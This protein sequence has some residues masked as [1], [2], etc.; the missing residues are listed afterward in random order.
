MKSGS[1]GETA[2]TRLYDAHFEE[3][4]RYL[5]LRIGNVTEAEDL[6]SQTFY[7][8]LRGFS[9]LR[10][11][12]TSAS[13]WLYRIATNE[14]NSH[15]RRRRSRSRW[16]A[17]TSPAEEVVVRERDTA[18]ERLRREEIFMQLSG[19]LRR[20][21]P[22]EQA[23]V[24]LRYFER[25]PYAEIARI[26]RKREGTLAMRTHRALGKMRAELEKRGVDHE[27]IRESF[28]RREAAG[29]AGRRVQA[30]ATP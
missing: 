3:I 11:I 9:R 18:E 30:G 2:F 6:T 20:L 7:K 17:S 23:L 4:F 21:E 12:G 27:G 13:A 25:K 28:A 22:D 29:A 15:F 16:E 8:A 14:L 5:L 1:E 24:V 19:A 26:L 10:L